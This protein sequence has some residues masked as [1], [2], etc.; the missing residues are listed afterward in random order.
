MGSALSSASSLG[1]TAFGVVSNVA[2]SSVGLAGNVA[3]A[4]I[5]SAEKTISPATTLLGGVLDKGMKT[6]FSAIG[7]GVGKAGNM[8]GGAMSFMGDAASKPLN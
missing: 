1:S 6:A 4:A 7:N 8:L 3:Q 2:S 5:G